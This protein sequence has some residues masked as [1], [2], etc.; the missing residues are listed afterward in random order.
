MP[1][2]RHDRGVVTLKRVGRGAISRSGRTAQAQKHKCA[3]AVDRLLAHIRL[4]KFGLQNTVVRPVNLVAGR[5][6]LLDDLQL[7][8]HS[9]LE[10]ENHA[11]IAD[12]FRFED[13]VPL[14][15]IGD[16]VTRMQSLD[17]H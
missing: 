13:Y 17:G 12:G 16:R 10:F 11:T 8:V 2:V 14:T 7:V 3:V 4:G 1:S 9:A 6:R 5:E 15:A